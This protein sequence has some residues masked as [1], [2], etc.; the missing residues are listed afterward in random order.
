LG[1][2]IIGCQ[3]TRGEYLFPEKQ[4][5]PHCSFEQECEYLNSNI[6]IM[7]YYYK[8]TL[9]WQMYENKDD[10]LNGHKVTYFNISVK[11]NYN[12]DIKRILKIYTESY[13]DYVFIPC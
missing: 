6:K 5:Y 10:I 12:H 11:P 4:V 13:D 2:N 7:N 3:F 8:N 1:L 9:K